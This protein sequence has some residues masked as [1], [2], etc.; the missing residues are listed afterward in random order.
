MKAKDFLEDKAK[1]KVKIF[2]SST[3]K[4]D[5]QIEEDV[6][7]WLVDKSD[8]IQIFDIKQSVVAGD[9]GKEITISVWYTEY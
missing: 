9:Y 7:E 3:L 4:P 1:K 8:D 5:Q 6:N 2:S